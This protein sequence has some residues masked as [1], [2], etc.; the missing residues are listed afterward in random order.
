MESDYFGFHISNEALNVGPELCS[1]FLMFSDQE[2]YDLTNDTT[3]C[4]D[5]IRNLRLVSYCIYP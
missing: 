4:F 3:V 5:L 1:F 2:L